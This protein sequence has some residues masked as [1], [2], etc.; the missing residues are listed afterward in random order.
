MDALSQ[1]LVNPFIHIRNWVKGEQLN[2]GALIAAIMEK[3][4]CETRKANAIKRLA[5]DRD[6]V[7]KLSEGK[8]TFKH[9]FKSESSKVK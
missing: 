4:A 8:F 3:E 6:I 2:L 1:D 7:H 9:M 5:D